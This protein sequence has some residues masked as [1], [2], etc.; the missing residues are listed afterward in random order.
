MKNILKLW[1]QIKQPIRYLL[2]GGFNTVISLCLF[3]VLYLI[4]QNNLNY[5]TIAIIAHFISVLNS[6]I[7][8]RLFVFEANGSFLYNYFKT[9]IS[10]LFYLALNLMLL[11]VLCDLL[12]IYPIYGSIIVVCILTPLF[13]FIH[14][15]FSFK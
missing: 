8:F 5:L 10:Y 6:T 15:F 4:L 3:A 12:G 11:Y 14:K 1:F 13:F 9:N 7:T 2:V